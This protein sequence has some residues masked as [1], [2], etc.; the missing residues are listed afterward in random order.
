MFLSRLQKSLLL[1]SFFVPAIY[2]QNRAVAVMP[3]P[4]LPGFKRS[5]AKIIASFSSPDAVV[6]AP[7]QTNCSSSTNVCYYF[8]A[9]ILTAYAI[10]S[11]A[12]GNGGAGMTVGIVDAYYNP[13]TEADLATYDGFAGLPACTIAGGCLTIVNQTGGSP[14]GVG[15]NEGWAQET[16]L[17]VQTVHALAP[18]AKILL[19]AAN[20][21]SDA[22]LGAGVLY[23]RAHAQ[24]VSDSWGGGE[25]PSE[26]A[27][28]AAFYAGS[29]VPL[30]FSSGDFGAEVQYPCSS[31]YVTCVGGTHLLTTPTSFRNVESAW[32][33]GVQGDNDGA[34]GGCSTVEAVLPAQVGFSTCG[35]FRGVP[36]IGAL[37]DPYTGFLVALGA[38]AAGGAANAGI[39]VFGGTS[40]A[41]PLEAAIIASIDT[42][43]VA[44]GKAVLGS[45]LN[46]LIYQ[47]AAGALYRY[48]YYDVATG[49][50][51]F[52]ATPSWDEVTGLGVPLA[53]SLASYL[54]TSVP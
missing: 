34:G 41:S 7:G 16:N 8:P 24:V 28:D 10:K 45:N 17:D 37:A 21:N 13:Q 27:D 46:A 47:A 43:R 18:K 50:S 33:D 4:A 49:N 14:T 5:H 40:L 3:G 36:D 19:V 20:D 23:A 32:G 54:V 31:L 35:A 51:G 53:P 12:N 38:N 29:P 26:L 9:D 44:A 52:P 15:F 48:R 6:H 25:D 11:I 42:A 1:A 30:L 2:A 22:N 39:Y